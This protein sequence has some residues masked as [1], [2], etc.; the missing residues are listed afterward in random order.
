MWEKLAYPWQVCVE[1][2]WAAYCAGS[3]PI[4]AVVTDMAGNVIARGR[5]RIFERGAEDGQVHGRRLAHAEV[6]ALLNLDF[7]IDPTTCVLYVT[8]E[9]CPLCLGALCI[10][11]VRTLKYA[12]RDPTA[13]SVDL[14]GATPFLRSRQISVAGP[15]SNDF[16]AVLVALRVE[17]RFQ[18]GAGAGVVVRNLE[19]AVP[20]GARL[21]TR[22]FE[23]GRL[24]RMCEAGVGAP[25]MLDELFAML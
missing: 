21:G 16:E 1:E 11:G 23:T 15:E 2:A 22:L 18:M 7:N 8:T 20:R 10:S 9:P 12:A 3:L 14:L 17:R 25:A 5:N 4:G 24:Q 6:N 13:G 19:A